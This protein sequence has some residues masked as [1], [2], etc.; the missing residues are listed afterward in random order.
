MSQ[1]FWKVELQISSLNCNILKVD[2]PLNGFV[3]LNSG[4]VSAVE[5]LKRRIR[6]WFPTCRWTLLLGLFNRLVTISV[7]LLLGAD[8][9]HPGRRGRGG[10]GRQNSAEPASETMVLLQGNVRTLTISWAGTEIS[11]QLVGGT[12]CSSQYWPWTAQNPWKREWIRDEDIILL[13]LCFGFNWGA[14]WRSRTED[15]FS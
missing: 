4:F 9:L 7:L 12:W 3:N 5:G 14:K 6:K 15:S 8:P 10:Q 11:S 13:L 1:R 2:L